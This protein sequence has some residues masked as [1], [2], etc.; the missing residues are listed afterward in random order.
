MNRFRRERVLRNGKK[1]FIGV[2]C[3]KLVILSNIFI[4][5]PAAVE[6]ILALNICVILNHLVKTYLGMMLMQE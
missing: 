4:K 6:E 2:R 3:I 1:F 5:W